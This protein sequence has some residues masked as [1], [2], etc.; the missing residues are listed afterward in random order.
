MAQT[1]L[2]HLPMA[3]FFFPFHFPSVMRMSGN[4]LKETDPCASCLEWRQKSEK[5]TSHSQHSRGPEEEKWGEENSLKL[6][7]NQRKGEHR[8]PTEV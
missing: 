7:D 6:L 8:E 4:I 1:Y 5:T 2:D 3:D